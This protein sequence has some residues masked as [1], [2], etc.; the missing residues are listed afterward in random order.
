[1]VVGLLWEK[2]FKIEVVEGAEDDLRSLGLVIVGCW[3]SFG[4]VF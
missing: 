1:M 4:D 3:T 2:F